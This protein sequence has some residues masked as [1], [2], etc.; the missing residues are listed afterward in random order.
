MVLYIDNNG[1]VALANNKSTGYQSHH[2]DVKQKYICE[3][4]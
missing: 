2:I 4:K 3:L 1:A